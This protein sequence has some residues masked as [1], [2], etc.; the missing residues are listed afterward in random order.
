M[1]MIDILVY[2]LLFSDI[3][4]TRFGSEAP[5]RVN[6]RRSSSVLFKSFE[7]TLPSSLHPQP[8]GIDTAFLC[9]ISTC[10]EVLILEEEGFEAM[11]FHIIY[12][13][14]VYTALTHI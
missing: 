10:N 9:A 4:P 2:C 13:L 11:Y 8:F 7:F 1:S 6:H 3:T 12:E 14:F 5:G